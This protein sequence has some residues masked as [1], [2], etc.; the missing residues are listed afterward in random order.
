MKSN[1]TCL[2]YTLI[3]MFKDSYFP[4]I[5]C[6]CMT[7]PLEVVCRRKHQTILIPLGKSSKPTLGRLCTVLPRQLGE[8][9]GLVCSHP[10]FLPGSACQCNLRDSDFLKSDGASSCRILNRNLCGINH[11]FRVLV[12]VCSPCWSVSVDQARLHFVL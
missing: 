8:R 12:C 10:C 3:F 9:N 6:S 7:F 2:K 4:L 1:Q 5:V 11:D